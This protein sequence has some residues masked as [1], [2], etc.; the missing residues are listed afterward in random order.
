NQ[1]FFIEIGL[2]RNSISLLS[3]VSKQ[4]G[5]FREIPAAFLVRVATCIAITAAFYVLARVPQQCIVMTT[6]VAGVTVT[7]ISDKRTESDKS[8]GSRVTRHRNESDLALTG[9]AT[10]PGV[11]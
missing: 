4:T 1:A 8:G 9:N 2:L 6:H 7:E 10:R 11:T 5:C 3:L